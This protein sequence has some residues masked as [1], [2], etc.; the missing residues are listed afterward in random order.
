MFKQ[1]RRSSGRGRVKIS[2]SFHPNIAMDQQPQAGE[3]NEEFLRNI[4]DFMQSHVIQYN[5]VLKSITVTGEKTTE[6]D[7]IKISREFY[8][9]EGMFNRVYNFMLDMVASDFTYLETEMEQDTSLD[10]E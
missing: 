9:S 1:L 6:L 10:E 2:G 7:K 8:R 5:L 3:S 4:V